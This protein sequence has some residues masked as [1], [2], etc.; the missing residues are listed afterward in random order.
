MKRKHALA[1]VTSAFVSFTATCGFGF[2]DDL[3]TPTPPTDYWGWQCGDGTPAS[4]DGGCL[5]LDCD[6]NST[7]AVPDGGN[8]DAGSPCLCRD[9]TQVLA[10]TCAG[11][12]PA[13]GE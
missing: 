5:P 4:F 2:G 7:P 1:L 8:V 13:S 12:C 9:G 11:D 3:G 6:D 10:C